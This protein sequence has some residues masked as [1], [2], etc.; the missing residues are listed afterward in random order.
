LRFRVVFDTAKL[1]VIAARTSG[2]APNRIRSR[3]APAE[4]SIGDY[5]GRPSLFFHLDQVYFASL[6]CLGIPRDG[7]TSRSL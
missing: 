3:D 7:R 1:A 4:G 6:R 2:T 5:D